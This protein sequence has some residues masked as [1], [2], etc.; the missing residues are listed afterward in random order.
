MGAG[1]EVLDLRPILLPYPINRV[2]MWKY[3]QEI[4]Q[5]FELHVLSENKS[6]MWERVATHCKQPKDLS[7]A[8]NSLSTAY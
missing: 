1:S 3:D 7:K 8:L 2:I 5:K 6:D 4:G